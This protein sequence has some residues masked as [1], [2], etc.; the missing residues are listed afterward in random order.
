MNINLIHNALQHLL[1]ASEAYRD[2]GFE[3]T[4]NRLNM[5]AQ[6][7]YNLAENHKNSINDSSKL[8]DE[9]YDLILKEILDA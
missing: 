6:E 9:E 8:S 7:T 2:A 1:D 5:L 4:S 3:E